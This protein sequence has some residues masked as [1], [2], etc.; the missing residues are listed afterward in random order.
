M[1]S[2]ENNF[3]FQTPNDKGKPGSKHSLGFSFHQEPDTSAFT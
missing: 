1:S 3:S 2:N